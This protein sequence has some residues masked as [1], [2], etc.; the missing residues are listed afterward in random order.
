M[1]QLILASIGIGIII[2]FLLVVVF[3]GSQEHT[4]PSETTGESV[5]EERE[6]QRINLESDWIID[7]ELLDMDTET[8]RVTLVSNPTTSSIEPEDIL[9]SDGPMGLLDEV[10]S[11]ESKDEEQVVLITVPTTAAE[12]FESVS[13]ETKGEPVE[14]SGTL[15][16]GEDLCLLEPYEELVGDIPPCDAITVGYYYDGD[17]CKQ[18]T[19]GCY[20]VFPFETLEECQVKCE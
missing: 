6:P 18:K 17:V 7:D 1:K 9:I 8:A 2:L 19:L 14:V 12:G 4:A 15:R 10:I 5:A 3:N 13:H 16:M 11:V 20:G